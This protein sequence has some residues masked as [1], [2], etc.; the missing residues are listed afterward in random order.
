MAHVAHVAMIIPPRSDICTS[1]VSEFHRIVSAAGNCEHYEILDQ[2][3]ACRVSTKGVWGIPPHR[4]S[5]E[6]VDLR[7]RG[8][9]GDVMG[10]KGKP[11]TSLVHE[12]ISRLV[13][14]PID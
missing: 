10:K 14:K 6:W 1:L 8:D 11:C 5:G 9:L 3:A 13:H 7:V 12:S 2:D 4:Q